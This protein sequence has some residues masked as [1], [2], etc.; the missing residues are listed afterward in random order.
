M[1]R[2]GARVPRRR[3]V[4]DLGDRTPAMVGIAALLDFTPRLMLGEEEIS[5]EEAK[6]LLA[7]VD[8]LAFIKNKWVAVD[9]EKLAQTLAAYEEAQQLSDREDLTLA[10]AM[11]M[12]L[13]P[14]AGLLQTPDNAVIEVES[15]QW[16]QSVFS[17][18]T[19]PSLLP[20]ANTNAKR[21]TFLRCG[22]TNSINR[23]LSTSS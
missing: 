2:L 3:H 6:R 15:G 12:Q 22:E 21:I 19:N 17:K 20:K 16:L 18:M 4:E 11:R 10:E 7:E 23:A 8:G 14:Q 13:Q 1:V 5:S 9:R